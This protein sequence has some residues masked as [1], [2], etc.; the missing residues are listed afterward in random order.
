MYRTE[1][2]ILS[3]FIALS[4][5]FVLFLAQLPVG[6]VNVAMLIAGCILGVMVHH[7]VQRSPLL[8]VSLKHLTD[9]ITK[10]G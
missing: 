1:S 10:G 7:T 8:Q 3:G 2:M 4:I 9:R 5:T 6:I